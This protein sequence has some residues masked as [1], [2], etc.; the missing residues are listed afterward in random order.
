M[1]KC[2]CGGTLRVKDHGTWVGYFCPKCK[3]GGSKKKKTYSGVGIGQYLPQ[4]V[5][6]IDKGRMSWNSQDKTFSTECSNYGIGVPP[7]TLNLRNCKTG[8][9]K[10]FTRT[11]IDYADDTH[12]DIAGYWYS[13]CEGYSLL[14]IND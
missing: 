2:I 4:V 3:V 1:E 9:V 8:N 14:L 10:T 6:D 7:E 11:K 5:L 13:N 12:E